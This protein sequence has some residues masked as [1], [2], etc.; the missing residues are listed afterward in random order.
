MADPQEPNTPAVEPVVPQDEQIVD[1]GYTN[2]DLHRDTFVD[3]AT[4]SE[5]PKAD[6]PKKDEDPKPDEKP[7][8]NIEELKEQWKQEARAEFEATLEAKQKE[9]DEQKKREELKK[10]EFD[11][12]TPIWV[13]EGR[14]PKDYNEIK[15]QS[16]KEARHEFMRLQ[17]ERDAA[18]A[19]EEKK[20]TEAAE[21]AKK[22]EEE[23][24]KS[25]W[26]AINIELNDLY[27]MGKL[28]PIK[29]ADN[30][31]DQGVLEREEL[32]KQ[33]SQENNKRRIENK[34][35]IM[36]AT[37]FVEFYY[38]R[39]TAQPPGADLPIAGN[40]GSSKGQADAE[41]PGYTYKDLKKPWSIFGRR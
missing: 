27:R 36:S 12:M 26:D 2:A 4:N 17:Q 6:D 22:V 33:W 37:Q 16:V 7:E 10:Q 39:P 28:T 40:T 24:V 20:K 18:H 31:S 29:D 9:E 35:Q 41:N 14:E 11:E 5:E 32:M 25:A 21:Q 19:E 1:P 38:K 30:K 15:E 3:I 8:V 34:P 23:T 13:K